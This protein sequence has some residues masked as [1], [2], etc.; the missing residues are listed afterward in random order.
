MTVR[1]VR[2]PAKSL[3]LQAEGE[4]INGHAEPVAF[5]IGPENGPITD[6][7]VV[8]ALREANMKGY[9]RLLVVGLSIQPAAR[10]TI[11]TAGDAGIPANYLQ[12]TPDLLMGDLLK[13]MRSSQVFSVCG[14][15]EI[16]VSRLPAAANGKPGSGK[17]APAEPQRYQV[18]LLGLDVF[19]PITMAN[20]YRAGTDVRR[21][22]WTWITTTVASSP[23][24]P[25]SP[26]RPPGTISVG[27]CEAP[28]R[29]T[30]G[31]TSPV[32]SAPV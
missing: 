6:R 13:N 11:S 5:L 4:L 22:F 3:H 27:N 31:T 26:G 24:N 1:N 21:G 10:L 25:S 7:Q 15:P 19:D 23:G 28:L 32:R 20:S 30:F 9:V 29:M 14:L 8:K 18:E 2:P 17:K 16:K 12:V